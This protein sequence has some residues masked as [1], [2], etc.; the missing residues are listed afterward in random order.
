MRTVILGIF[1][2]HSTLSGHVASR[3]VAK[4]KP[5]T[6]FKTMLV[7]EK[8]DEGGTNLAFSVLRAPDG[9]KLTLTHHRFDTQIDAQNFFCKRIDKAA[10]IISKTGTKD[11]SGAIVGQRAEVLVRA[12][13]GSK[14]PVSGIIWTH[15]P[16]FHEIVSASPEDNRLLEAQFP[17]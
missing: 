7:G 1:L 12:D 5:P 4:P 9:I 3:Q 11:K 2:F 13:G 14:A 8:R 17:D 15:G 16:E 10:K 6:S